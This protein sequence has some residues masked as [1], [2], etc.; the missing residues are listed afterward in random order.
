M[1]KAGSPALLRLR[2]EV[3]C[4]RVDWGPTVINSVHL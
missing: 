1:L 2:Q 3:S 4:E